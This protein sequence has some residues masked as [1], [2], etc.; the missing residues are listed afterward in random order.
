M[1]ISIMAITWDTSFRER[2]A[3]SRN[4]NPKKENRISAPITPLQANAQPCLKPEIMYGNAAG[5]KTAVINW[6]PFAPIFLAASMKCGSI[7]FTPV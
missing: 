5:I 2:P 4:P 3:L 7:F 1:I 6:V